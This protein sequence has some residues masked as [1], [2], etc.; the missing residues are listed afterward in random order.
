MAAWGSLFCPCPRHQRPRQ[1]EDRIP[2]TKSHM[3]CQ[4]HTMTSPS[5]V[6]REGWRLY[7]GVL[8]SCELKNEARQQPLVP[9]PE[10]EVIVHI[11]HQRVEDLERSDRLAKGHPGLAHTAHR[12]LTTNV[13]R[14]V[15]QGYFNEIR[16][17]AEIIIG[18]SIVWWEGALT[19]ITTHI[20]REAERR[21]RRPASR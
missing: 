5:S 16:V 12:H 15:N 2:P 10:V 6:G 7:V 14:H 9:H 20:T 3:T 11:R 19:I 1:A 4:Q 13:Q 8:L 21:P 17:L 18:K